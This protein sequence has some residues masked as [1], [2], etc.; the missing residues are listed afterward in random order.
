MV[1]TMEK[2]KTKRSLRRFMLLSVG[3]SIAIF[4][5]IFFFV[6]QLNMLRILVRTE[7]EQIAKLNDVLEG[8]IGVVARDLE[9][10]AKDIAFW[11][12]TIFFVNDENP[13]YL[14]NWVGGTILEYNKHD[15]LILKNLDGVDK[16]Y[17]ISPRVLNAV[18][19]RE[20]ELSAALNHLCDEAIANYDSTAGLANTGLQR[21]LWLNNRAYSVYILPI[22]DLESTDAPVGTTIVGNLIDNE[23]MQAITYYKDTEFYVE[24]LSTPLE[25]KTLTVLKTEPDYL[26]GAYPLNSEDG[27]N[28]VIMMRIH[29]AVYIQGQQVVKLSNFILFA[30][31]IVFIAVMYVVMTLYV[32]NPVERLSNAVGELSADKALDVS[33]YDSSRELSNLCININDMIQR[34]EDSEI[35]AIE[36]SA[37]MDT[38][39]QILNGVDAL[40]YVT[41]LDTDDILYINDKMTTH[42][43]LEGELI[44]QKCWKVLQSGMTERCSFCPVRTLLDADIPD[45]SI[46]WEEESSATGRTYRNTDCLINWDGNKRAH[47]QHSV[48]ITDIKQ[49][50]LA[51]SHQLEQQTLMSDITQSFISTEN[52]TLLI[53]NALRMAGEFLDINKVS[54]A[55][56]TLEAT[57]M[58]CDIRYEWCSSDAT[59]IQRDVKSL[60]FPNT[61]GTYRAFVNGEKASITDDILREYPNEFSPM[62]DPNIHAFVSVPVYA[63]ERLWGIISFSDSQEG[64]KWRRGEE[65]LFRMIASVI[66]GVVRRERTEKAL[67]RMSSITETSPYLVACITPEGYFEYVNAGTTLIT[68]YSEEEL[69]GSSIE[70]LLAPSD[71]AIS[72]EDVIRAVKSKGDMV[73]EIP[74]VRKDGEQRIGTFSV[75]S[76]GNETGLGVIASDITEK[77]KMESDLVV[78]KEQAEDA[79]QAKGDF[80]ARMSHEMRTPMNAI[81][82]MTNIAK[83]SSDIERKEYC[84]DKIDDASRHLLG[85]INDVLDMSKI[86]A[87]KFELSSSEFSFEKMLMRVVDVVNFK[88]EEKNQRLMVNVDNRIP[89]YLIADEQ[90]IAQVIANLMSNA[91]KFTPDSGDISLAAELIGTADDVYRIRI[92]VTDTGIGITP[93][94]KA[95]LFRSFEQADG[96]ISR[97]FGGT[98]LGLAISKRIIELMGGDIW[99]ESEIDVGSTFAFEVE[100]QKGIETFAPRFAPDVTRENVRVLI[101]DDDADVLEAFLMMMEPQGVHCEAALSGAIALDLIKKAEKPF[102]IAFVDWKMPELDGIELT[103]RIKEQS[104]NNTVIIMVSAAE[105]SEIETEA[106]AAGVDR[107]ISKPLFSSV[108]ND[109]INMCLGI[110]SVSKAEQGEEHNFNGKCLLLAEDVEINREIVI[111]LLEDTGL[112][113]V[114]AENGVIALETFTENP[115]KFDMIFMDIH[116]PEMDGLEASRRIRALDD[117]WSKAVPIVAMTANVFREDIERCLD[118]GM[119]DH[120]GK[121]I[122]LG[123]M[124]DKLHKYL[125]NA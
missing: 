76:I 120:T 125:F 89:R 12:E 87:N 6:V 88:V 27:V 117:E 79:S 54:L 44:G 100:M 118:A 109:A 56:V 17:E 80:L 60:R 104:G 108:I 116:M 36:S 107:F 19:G 70:G 5:V 66:S 64:R 81:I 42:Y 30:L 62:D 124:M 113:I 85:I 95:K 50:E 103:R 78:A 23:R 99:V 53:E 94:Q 112:E 10:L 2:T 24:A 9:I 61:S 72:H 58:I 105:W 67:T 71:G 32:I 8:T 77:R 92:S 28:L 33:K 41:D 25:N 47:L 114:C 11:D 65:Q 46:T 86:E 115:R 26:Y 93:E 91:V 35:R 29:R 45:H 1:I 31:A 43:G 39:M 98:G 111:T 40:L 63:G 21:V 38:V 7:D 15:L 57:D 84:L 34:I 55:A 119:N 18:N 74:F 49:S 59:Q 83:A 122:D 4:V 51:I 97:R 3:L 123:E 121:P 22:V 75:F 96:G 102:N 110:G 101:V 20:S 68:G 14:G 73:F 82:G 90:R 52:T 13:D 16:H 37:T 69:L 48:D 106:R